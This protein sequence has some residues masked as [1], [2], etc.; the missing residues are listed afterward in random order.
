MYERW[1]PSKVS[2]RVV[3]PLD[4]ITA[5]EVEAGCEVDAG[6]EVGDTDVGTARAQANEANSKTLIAAMMF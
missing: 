2:V 6:V 3:S 5:A 4:G 1:I